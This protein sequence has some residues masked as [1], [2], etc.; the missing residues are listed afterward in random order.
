MFPEAIRIVLLQYGIQAVLALIIMLILRKF[1]RQYQNEYFQYWSFSW[2]AL[3]INMLG[4]AVTLANAFLL[5]LNH[6]FRLFSSVITIS[7]GFLQVLWLYMGSFELSQ[8]KR[9]NPVAAKIIAISI[10]PI[11]IVLVMGFYSDPEAGDLR[12]FLRVGIKSFFAGI[13]FIII[14]ILL[15]KMIQT[16]IGIKFILVSFLLYGLLQFNFFIVCVAKIYDHAY[17]AHLP[18]FMGDVDLFLQCLMGL[19]MI[20]SVLEIEQDSLKKAN[21]ELDTFLYRSSHDLR[22]PLTT[23]SGIVQV[24]KMEKN[25]EKNEI[26]LN[27]INE[28]IDQADNVIK[29]IIT[30]RKGQKLSLNIQEV[31]LEKELVKEFDLLKS[32]AI[33]SPELQLELTGSQMI[34]TDPERLH[35]VLTNILSN[36]IK[37]HNDNQ[38][39]RWIRVESTRGDSGI[40]LIISDN[41]LGIEQKHLP[42]IFE[43]FYRANQSSNGS[44]LGL[45]LVKDALEVMGGTIEIQSEKGVGTDFKLFLKDF[46]EVIL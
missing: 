37:Y 5:P 39:N 20:I 29:D 24:L 23:I 30:L 22:A 44:G 2:M 27:L 32:P 8:S 26:Y 4:S 6:P 46:K 18:Y 34:A 31:D 42:R 38:K 21:N 16:G 40:T 10:L 43:M 13:I 9:F 19:G 14:S 36:S 12:I 11:A 7:A 45:Y 1:Y 25:S 33:E 28:R 3:S 15:S 41:G 35:T 17:A